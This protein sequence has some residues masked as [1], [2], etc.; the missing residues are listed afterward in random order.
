MLSTFN[1]AATC[2]CSLVSM[3][4]TLMTSRSRRFKDLVEKHKFQLTPG[5]GIAVR[6]FDHKPDV[7]ASRDKG[8]VAGGSSAIV[9]N[10]NEKGEDR[11]G[12]LQRPKKGSTPGSL[13]S[14]RKTR[15]STSRQSFPFC[16]M[17]ADNSETQESWIRRSSRRG[18]SRKR[19]RGQIMRR[20]ATRQAFFSQLSS[21]SIKVLTISRQS[22][23]RSRVM[24]SK[25][26]ATPFG[27]R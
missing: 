1:M 8:S 3:G 27:R 21:L 25:L 14:A 20:C 7:V 9:K 26:Q 6:P 22:R 5:N 19:L 15:P 18:R 24:V 13:A 16:C 11:K 23:T 12:E 17:Q 10:K 2:R 4:A